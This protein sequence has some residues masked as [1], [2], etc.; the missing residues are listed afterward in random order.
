METICQRPLNGDLGLR[1]AIRHRQPIVI[2]VRASANELHSAL[3]D[4]DPDERSI[5]ESQPTPQVV[6][7]DEFDL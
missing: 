2:C 1:L 4:G 6:F 3:K 7:G 5:V